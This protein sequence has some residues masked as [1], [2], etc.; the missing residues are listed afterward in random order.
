[1]GDTGALGRV[2]LQGA[3]CWFV[4]ASLFSL[5]LGLIL[6]HLL[7]P[8]VGPQPA[9]PAGHRRDRARPSRRSTSTTSSRISSPPRSSRR[10]RPTRSCQ[11][12][13]FSVFFG[14]AITA[15][16]ERGRA[17][18]HGDRRAGRGDAADHR[19]CDARSRRSRCSPRSPRALAEQGPGVIGKLA[20]FMGSFYLG[21]VAAVGAADRRCV[22]GRRAGAPAC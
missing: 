3:R 2:G 16:G 12:V 22:P 6:V 7:Q 19:L 8:G 5:T 1:M 11:I 15:V 4:C 14:V 9:A 21:L 10:W 18:G 17:A 13:V 20:Y